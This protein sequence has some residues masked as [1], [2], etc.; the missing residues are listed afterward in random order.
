MSSG[1]SA[2]TGPTGMDPAI[3]GPHFWFVLH[4]VSF[5]YSDQPSTAQKEAIRAFYHSV[6]DILPCGKCRQHYQNYLSHYPIEPH[7][8]RRMDLV[9]WVIQVHNFVNKSLG[10]PVYTEDAVMAIYAN[11]DPVSP[12][13]KVNME[14]ITRQKEMARNGRLWIFLILVGLGILAVKFIHSKYYYYI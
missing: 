9:R 12:F 14:Q 6:K 11:L 10:K 5:H 4:L 1:T 2:S 3:W 8:D 13:V 7:L